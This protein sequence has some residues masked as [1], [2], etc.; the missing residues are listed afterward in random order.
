METMTELTVA[1]HTCENSRRSSGC[2]DD[3]SRADDDDA[4]D[5]DVGVVVVVAEE[6]APVGTRSCSLVSTK[7]RQTS[8]ANSELP[9][10]KPLS[11]ERAILSH[12]Y[13]DY[14]Y[15]A[16]T[17]TASSTLTVTSTIIRTCSIPIG[18]C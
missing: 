10:Q 5:D 4:D 2:A 18:V 12:K 3:D 17:D 11:W 14:H 15:Y 9:S 13:H 8:S 7:Q 1:G 6:A 16:T